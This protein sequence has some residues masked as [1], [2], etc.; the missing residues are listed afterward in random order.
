M[1]PDSI[2]PPVLSTLGWLATDGELVNEN[3][4][5]MMESITCFNEILRVDHGGATVHP[6][7]LLSF[8]G[9][10]AQQSFDEA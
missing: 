2:R 5:A 10:E 6:G 9:R 1:E 7:S 3:W 4:R 8:T